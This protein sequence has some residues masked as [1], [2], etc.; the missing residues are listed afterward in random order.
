MS[1][2]PHSPMPKSIMLISS[3]A[4]RNNITAS[5]AIEEGKELTL[6]SLDKCAAIHIKM[7][8]ELTEEFYKFRQQLENKGVVNV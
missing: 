8:F 7:G 4:T 3:F 6:E 5:F 2:H 1:I